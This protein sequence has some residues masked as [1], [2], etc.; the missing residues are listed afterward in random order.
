[1]IPRSMEWMAEG[2]MI[3][4][5]E[6][7]RGLGGQ[8]IIWIICMDSEITQDGSRSWR[9]EEHCGPGTDSSECRNEG[10]WSSAML[11]AKEQGQYVLTETYLLPL[12][13]R[14]YPRTLPSRKHSSI[15]HPTAPEAFHK[16]G[17]L[18][19]SCGRRLTMTSSP[20]L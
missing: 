16:I 20:F 9:R 17:I 18:R 7:V 1:M 8:G 15:P 14:C 11:D 10:I 4:G 3:T 13:K 12:F 19:R 5:V 2:E 6:G